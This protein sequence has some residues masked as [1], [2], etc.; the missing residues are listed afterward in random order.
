MTRKNPKSLACLPMSYPIPPSPSQ[1]C[2]GLRKRN[3]LLKFGVVHSVYASISRGELRLGKWTKLGPAL[4]KIVLGRCVHRLY[5][6]TFRQA[7]S[8]FKF[9]ITSS[10]MA[11]MDV[12]L[13]QELCWTAM[14]SKVAR[15]GI[16]F[17][18]SHDL[19]ISAI[20]LAIALEPVRIMMRILFSLSKAEKVDDDTDVSSVPGI[21]IFANHR[22]SPVLLALQYC[23]SLLAEPSAPRCMM[24]WKM[25]GCTS[26]A[27]FYDYESNVSALGD[28]VLTCSSWML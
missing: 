11:S 20:Q 27:E 15:R 10:N 3:H 24:V 5:E 12:G 13:Q 17:L 19:G 8:K 26:V 9:K 4:D 14:S 7:F 16:E 21:C 18:E 25:L 22:E 23:S 28:A 6:R 2:F 1:T